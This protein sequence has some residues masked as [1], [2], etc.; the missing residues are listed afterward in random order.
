MTK[1]RIRVGEHEIEVD[2]TP[3]EV[4]G[5][6]EQFYAR[7]QGLAKAS[8]AS[9]KERLLEVPPLLGK[10]A[11]PPTPAEFF[12]QKGK[13]DGLSQILIFAKYLEEYEGLTEFA[14]ADIN[15]V[16]KE[17]KLSKDVHPQ[18]FSNGVKQGLLRKSGQKY[19]L[20]LSAEE[21]LAAM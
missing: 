13:H 10:T 17:A 12:K 15:R 2:G 16:A 20:T 9:I 5:Y 3:T 11:K 18:Y 7:V 21:V 19:S 4:Q 14:P 1:I 6:V 8:P